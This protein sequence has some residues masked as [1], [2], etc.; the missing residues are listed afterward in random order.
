MN[1]KVE[2]TH[3]IEGKRI[4]LREVRLS[5]VNEDYYKWLNDNELSQYLETKFFPQSMELIEEYVANILG[6]RDNSFLAIIEKERDK[7]IGNIKLG[8]I[9]WIHRFADISLFIGDK[10]VWG[11][12]Y[13]TEAIKLVVDYAFNRLNLHRLQAG[14]YD[15]NIASIK[16][17]QKAGF[18][19]EANFKEKRFYNGSYMDEKIYGIVNE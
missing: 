13:G 2:Y 16:A 9:N 18:K 3:F 6:S 15:G 10:E 19:E 12:G 7:H 4:Y 8:S 1:N 17:F 11:K 14:I 5:D